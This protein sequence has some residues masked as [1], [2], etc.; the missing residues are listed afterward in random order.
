MADEKETG[1]M[2][3]A[4]ELVYK[5]L[6]MAALVHHFHLLTTGPGSYAKHVALG[7]LY[8]YC[9]DI[10]DTLAEKMMGA[11]KK[12]PDRA[13]GF[14][15][16]FTP[17]TQAIP[18]IEMFAAEFEEITEPPWLQNLAQEIQANLYAHLYKLK[19]LS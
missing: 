9:H 11:G 16:E 1:S 3:E 19:R 17:H 4:Q 7:D 2:D 15:L 14:Q 6:G 8:E 12:L 10:A 5:S 18:V 13:P